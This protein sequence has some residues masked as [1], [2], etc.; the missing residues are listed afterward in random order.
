M[1]PAATRLIHN[2]STPHTERYCSCT[3][4]REGISGTVAAASSDTAAARCAPHGELHTNGHKLRDAARCAAMA[5]DKKKKEKKK[6]PKKRSSKAPKVAIN[7]DDDEGPPVPTKKQSALKGSLAEKMMQSMGWKE[8]EGLG[9]NKQG[10]T[11]HVAV[12]KRRENE[13]LGAEHARDSG[14]NAAFGATSAGFAAALSALSSKYGG[15]A[16]RRRRRRRRRRRGKRGALHR[17]ARAPQEEGRA[18]RVWRRHEGAFSAGSSPTKK[19][20]VDED[21]GRGAR[22][23]RRSGGRRRPRKPPRRESA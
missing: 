12:I 5:T 4:T 17:E 19:R 23:R 1:P 16:M 3:R 11:D 13:G 8:G 21:E 15:D 6:L 18:D 20:P 9:K 22:G 2:C 14:G 7:D 10:I